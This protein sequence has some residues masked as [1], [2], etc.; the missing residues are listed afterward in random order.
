[1]GQIVSSN[2]WIGTVLVEKG[3]RRES[4][5]AEVVSQISDHLWADEGDQPN[6]GASGEALTGLRASTY[7]NGVLYE[8]GSIPPPEV[9]P[10]VG[11]HMWVDGFAPPDP[12]VAPL[13]NPD[14]GADGGST[15]KTGN[16]PGPEEASATGPSDK[17]ENGGSPDPMAPGEPPA[18]ESGEGS[19]GPDSEDVP[20]PPPHGGAGSS[21]SAWREYAQAVGVH[22]DEASDRAGVIAL[23]EA[24]G[25][26]V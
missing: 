18:S 2:T 19:S 6:I 5:P 1:M 22:V 26:P 14:P 21:E 8:K 12:P 4:L 10:L 13:I 23:I 7:I 16:E 3:A 24:A 25:K 20:P 11:D 9:I 15:P 17:P